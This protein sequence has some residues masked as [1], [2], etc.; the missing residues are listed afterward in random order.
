M[1]GRGKWFAA[2]DE[3]DLV[4][5]VS[6]GL[7]LPHCPTYR[8]T[9]SDAQSP[10]GRIALV[11]AVRSGVLEP[12]RELVDA[13]DGCVQCMG[14][15]PACPSGVRYDR[16]IEPAMAELTTRSLL[17]RMRSRVLL[18]PI[19]RRRLL[20][21]L[22]RIAAFA[23]RLRLVPKRLSMPELNIRRRK[24]VTGR[25]GAA[26]FAD[27][28]VTLFVGCVMSAWY[29][30]VHQA[31]IDVLERLGCRVSLTD[32]SQCC[33]ALHRHAGLVRRA[34]GFERTFQERP[35]GS[36]LLVNSAGCGANLM[37]HSTDA[38]DIMAYLESRLDDL[39]SVTERSDERVAI[40]DACH[41]RNIQRSHSSAHTVLSHLYEVEPIPDEGLCCG[42]GGAYAM[43]H[44]TAARAIVE[45]KYE[46]LRTT[47]GRW[48]SSGNP[49]CSAHMEAHLPDDLADRRI[50]HPIELVAFRLKAE[51]PK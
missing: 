48:I 49:G 19:G 14:C 25:S 45:R 32:A 7:C 20:F 6:C 28:E 47:T 1:T 18:F 37:T 51:E 9:G 50:V 42:A 22:T 39:L 17:R 33:G 40:H 24:L 16:I 27:V 3:S 8:I 13:L 23:Q 12:T 30:Q 15:L 34:E 46:A 43:A 10:R 41:L 38:I 21:A 36:L 35:S 26:P 11:T 4:S 44:P 29:T 2:V 5:C 31:T